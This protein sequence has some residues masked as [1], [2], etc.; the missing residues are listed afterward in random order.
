MKKK[1]DKY[2]QSLDKRTK[3]YK[4][5]KERKKKEELEAAKDIGNDRN[6]A[7]ENG[8]LGTFKPEALKEK[9]PK[10]KPVQKAKVETKKGVGD[11]VAEI[12]K[13]T[14]ID[15]ATKKIVEAVT[16]SDDCGCKDRQV[17]LNRWTYSTMEEVVYP[18]SVTSIKNG[19][20]R[21]VSFHSPEDFMAYVNKK[22][23]K[24]NLVRPF[25]DKMLC[26]WED[27]RRLH[28]ITRD[29]QV[30]IMIPTL[31]HLFN[32]VLRPQNCCI[33]QW[34]NLIDQIYFYYIEQDETQK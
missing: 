28:S 13:K 19:G 30:N 34:I 14:G 25:T 9:K 1:D 11:K 3:E 17:I 24:Y 32:L 33:D 7:V 20:V 8:R 27:F 4:Q 15:K 22:R 31:R 23:Q 6:K 2:Y 12:T 21:V 18:Y 10:R 26:D 16:G 29:Q 5:Y